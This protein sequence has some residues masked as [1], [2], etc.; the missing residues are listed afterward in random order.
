MVAAGA[1]ASAY[2]LTLL[3]TNLASLQPSGYYQQIPTLALGIGALAVP[4][5]LEKAHLPSLACPGSSLPQL[6]TTSELDSKG[7]SKEG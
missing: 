5:L 1:G 3:G 7:A 4:A 2:S 6:D